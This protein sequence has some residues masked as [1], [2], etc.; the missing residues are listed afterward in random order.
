MFSPKFAVLA[1][2]LFASAVAANPLERRC[3]SQG[4]SCAS[5]SCCA[6]YICTNGSYLPRSLRRIRTHEHAVAGNLTCEHVR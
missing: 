3:G 4:A 5:T 2:A 1:L 6:N